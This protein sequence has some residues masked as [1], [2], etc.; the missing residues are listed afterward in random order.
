MNTT[1]RVQDLP[2]FAGHSPDQERPLGGYG[3][4]MGA[5]G[6]LSVAFAAWIGRSGREVPERID[7]RD[8]A[9]VAVATHKVSRLIAK[10]RVTSTARAP[11]TR[12]EDDAGPGEVS[13]QARGRGLRRAIGELL[14]C[15][16]C[17]GMWIASAF[18]AGL[19]VA[20]RATRWIAGVLTALF[21]SDVLQIAYK[22]AE[23]TL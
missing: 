11:F 14:V 1:D 8:L 17:L 22:K 9:L 23:D 19:L 12:F 18:A 3:V 4:L 10:D 6:A 7:A 15:P 2:P 13:E 5:F 21:G 16:Y 20:P